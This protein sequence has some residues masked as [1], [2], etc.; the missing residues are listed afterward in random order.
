MLSIGNK[1]VRDEDNL[2]GQNLVLT[3]SSDPIRALTFLERVKLVNSKN[4]I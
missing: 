1:E 2:A 3:L 4:R